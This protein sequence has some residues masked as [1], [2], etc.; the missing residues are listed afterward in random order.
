MTN[1][2]GFFASWVRTKYAKLAGYAV[3]ASPAVQKGRL[4]H[5][6]RC[7]FH[8]EGTCTVCGCL[9]MAKAM[10]NTEKCPKDRWHRVW[11]RR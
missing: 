5:C 3:I 4:T 1:F 7:E 6:E 2:F 11:A 10:L 8:N 9:V